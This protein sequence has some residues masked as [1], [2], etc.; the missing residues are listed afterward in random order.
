MAAFAGQIA[1]FIHVAEQAAVVLVASIAPELLRG[2]ENG[3]D[4]KNERTP[5]VEVGIVMSLAALAGD[6][7]AALADQE[8]AFIIARM[9]GVLWAAAEERPGGVRIVP[10]TPHINVAGAAEKVGQRQRGG[11]RGRER[12]IV[13]RPRAA[14]ARA[15]I[16]GRDRKTIATGRRG[17]SAP[18]A[19]RRRAWNHRRRRSRPC[20]RCAASSCRQPSAVPQPGNPKA[21]S[22]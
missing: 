17:A 13:S 16:P 19:R 7:G 10:G 15:A 21:P 22:A 4:I 3:H 5:R 12:R 11:R 8:V 14:S 1:A 20:V 9:A 6:Q 18:P 2:I